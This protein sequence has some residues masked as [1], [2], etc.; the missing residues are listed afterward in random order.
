MSRRQT[1]WALLLALVLVL[2]AFNFLNFRVARSNTQVEHTLSIYRTG[3]T[4]PQNM[5]PGFGLHY[6]VESDERLARAL[7]AA[8]KT[9]L[10]TQ[11]PVGSATEIAPQTTMA[12]E[13]LLLVEVAPERL[14]TPF[15]GRATV[16]AQLFFAYDGDAPWPLDEAVVFNVSPAVKADGAFTLTDSSWGLISKEAY[17][18]HLAQALAENIAAALQGD[19]FRRP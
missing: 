5:T 16:T 15:Y 11:T 7:S 18:Q 17:H 1:L 14:W 9:E 19:V 8:L 2:L 12:E 3:Q 4:L 13:P 6:A 10:E